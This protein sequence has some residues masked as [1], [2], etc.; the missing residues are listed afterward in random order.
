[1]FKVLHPRNRPFVGFIL[2]R[3]THPTQQEES[4]KQYQTH[5]RDDLA[6]AE[7]KERD[8]LA[9]YLPAQLDQAQID[10]RLRVV[11]AEA[12]EKPHVGKVLKAFF[13]TVDR[14]VVDGHSEWY[15]PSLI[16]SIGDARANEALGLRVSCVRFSPNAL[17]PVIVSCG[18]DKVVK[19][20]LPEYG[21]FAFRPLTSTSRSGNSQNAS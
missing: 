12:G 13:E 19:V 1:M 6:E 18:W 21:S 8:F 10:E 16:T 2:T 9:K 7:I 20:S 11:L 4:A 5:S 14:N 17:N 3:G 15:V